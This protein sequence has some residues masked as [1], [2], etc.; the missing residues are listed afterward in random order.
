MAGFD[1]ITMNQA[2][3]AVLRDTSA[4]IGESL[5]RGTPVIVADHIAEYYY[6]GSDKE[7][8]EIKTDFPL[9]IPP[10]SRFWVEW[11]APSIVRSEQ[12]GISDPKTTT[13]PF[14]GVLVDAGSPQEMM[15]IWGAHELPAYGNLTAGARWVMRLQPMG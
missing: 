1:P 14:V 4:I 15:P 2:N 9:L 7:H 10:F 5:R 13:F 11:H 3:T 12:Y 6:A 8:W